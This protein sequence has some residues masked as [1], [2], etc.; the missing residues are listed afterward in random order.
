MIYM[1]IESSGCT[2]LIYYIF[3][4]QFY[5]NKAE[6]LN[7]IIKI[8]IMITFQLINEINK[9]NLNQYKSRL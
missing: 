9:W 7:K 1:Q 4:C 2:F 3:I 6:K 5:F 8:K